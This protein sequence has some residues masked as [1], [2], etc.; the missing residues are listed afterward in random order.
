[1]NNGTL[2]RGRAAYY[3]DRNGEY[4]FQPSNHQEWHTANPY[5]NGNFID[6]EACQFMSASDEE[7]LANK[8]K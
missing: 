3:V 7:F 6:F 5:G 2:D 4:V 1:M 8:E